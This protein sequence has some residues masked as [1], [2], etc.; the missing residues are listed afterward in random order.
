[1]KCLFS[2]TAPGTLGPGPQ[3]LPTRGLTATAPSQNQPPTSGASILQAAD[4]RPGGSTLP[5]VDNFTHTKRTLAA[6]I[7]GVALLIGALAATPAA[8]AAIVYVCQ[9]HHGGTV[10][11]VAKRTRCKRGEFKRALNTKGTKGNNG[12]DGLSGSSGSS[13]SGVKGATGPAGPSGANGVAGPVGAEG[14]QGKAGVPGETG[15]AGSTGAA[16]A[17]GVTGASGATG[18]A[19]ATGPTGGAGSNGANGAEGATGPTGAAGSN[20]SNGSTGPTGP[21]G[22]TTVTVVVPSTGGGKVTVDCGATSHAISGGSANSS[23][24]TKDFPSDS[25]GNVVATGTTNPRFWTTEF[26]NSNSGNRA[27]AVCVP[28]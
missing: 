17:A 14:K 11:F 8:D 27:F 10:R 1:M 24:E 25:G 5:A 22:A 13:G 26:T 18:A 15:A 28:N 16:G 4:R 21:A 7:A 19:G 23:A 6:L 2:R 9:K 20:G 12:S 3:E